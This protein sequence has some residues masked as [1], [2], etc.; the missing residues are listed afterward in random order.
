MTHHARSASNKTHMCAKRG[1][2]QDLMLPRERLIAAA[3]TKRGE[4]GVIEPL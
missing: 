2:I 3:D 4:P 1:T